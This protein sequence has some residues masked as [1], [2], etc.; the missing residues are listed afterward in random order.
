MSKQDHQFMNLAI[1]QAQKAI[2]TSGAFNVGACLVSNNYTILSTG[3]SR[4]M[5]GNTHAEECCFLKL[6]DFE[7]ARGS[8]I[9]TTMEPC[10][11]RLSGKT[12]CAKWIIHAGVRRVVQGVKEPPNFVGESI[13]TRLLTD[14][15]V[16]VD[17]LPGYEDQC[18]APNKHLLT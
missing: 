2:P 10:G 14:A 8:T 9:Y 18:L 3:Y 11:K 13:G 1:E 15:G 12:C 4:E 7:L 6:G 5:S 16:I 17:Y